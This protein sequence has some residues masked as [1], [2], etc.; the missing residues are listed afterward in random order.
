MSGLI[1]LRKL[2]AK[3]IGWAMV[4]A[5]PISLFLRWLLNSLG[6]ALTL[7]ISVWLYMH[8]FSETKPWGGYEL[9]I[10]IDELHHEAKT[11]VLT[12]L[13]T[14]V[15]FTVAFQ[16]ATVAW[17]TQALDQLKFRLADE[18]EKFFGETSTLVNEL[19]LYAERLIEVKSEID[20]KGVNA[21]T[22]FAVQRIVDQAPKF[23]GARERL[24][25]LDVEVHGIAG[26]NLG[27]LSSMA[28]APEYLNEA[29]S[30]LGEITDVMWLP[31]LPV[32][33]ADQ[34][35]TVGA[36]TNYTSVE[37][38]E[39]LIQVCEHFLPLITGGSGAL[40]G[41]L[42]QTVV[43]TNVHSI[44]YMRKN[45]TLFEGAFSKLDEARKAT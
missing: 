16:T 44:N 41:A 20:Q 9:A 36:F 39:K 6:G 32:S 14:V 24:S 26:R 40:V 22:S 4:Y 25:E 15:G 38:Y 11:G 21:G 35:I 27:L 5:M 42:R 30:A 29:I 18:I 2:N 34:A 8:F 13:V 31:V 23:A 12:A 7:L 17:K 43:T 3:R 45:R 10:W 37:K 1:V 19:T 28:G 33:Q